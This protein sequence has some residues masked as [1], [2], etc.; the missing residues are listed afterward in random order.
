MLIAGGKLDGAALA[1][2]VVIVTG[3][4]GG[5]GF[6]AARSLLHLG[7]RVVIA[8]IDATTGRDAE[9]R[10]AAEWASDRVM[11]VP[12]DV[13]DEQSVRHLCETTLERFGRIDVVLNNATYAPAGSAVAETSIDVWDRSYAVNLRGPAL[14]ARAVLPAMIAR[15][16][17]VFV[18]VSSTGGPFL[19]PYETLKA[20]QVA[21][22]NSLDA[23]LAD[24]GVIA[25]TIG[26]GLVPTRTATD[27]I[28]VLAPRLGMSVDKFW[29]DNSGAVLSV[30]AAGAGFA[31]AIV[32]AERYA[33]QEISSSQALIDAGID[34]AVDQATPGP[35]DIVGDVTSALELCARVEQTLADQSA[36][37]KQRSFFERQ[38]M[39]RDFKQR[40]GMPV[41]RCLETLALMRQRLSSGDSTAVD[42]D[43]LLLQKLGRF[44]A[45]MGEL[46]QGY[47]KDPQQRK[48]Q[49]QIVGGW[50][51]DVDGLTEQIAV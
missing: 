27:A 13:A 38:W 1:G 40:V 2:D 43:R 42:T 15:K 16:R 7:A 33:G 48:D 50:K 4:G 30:E 8:E 9:A 37:W 32:L 22:A 3:A 41:E 45:H 23:E 24:T 19:A 29:S 47:V 44:Y 28:A 5:I 39:L 12:T 26:P 36:D 6:E 46:A 14:L 35:R 11:F 18:C 17:G 34:T 21:L 20:A 25:F 51:A 31:A 10:L 49:L